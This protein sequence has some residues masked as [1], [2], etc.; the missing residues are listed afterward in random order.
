MCNT[1]NSN[2]MQNILFNPMQKFMHSESDSL[3]VV[4]VRYDICQQMVCSEVDALLLLDCQN[5]FSQKWEQSTIAHT[6]VLNDL[7]TGQ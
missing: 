2:W 7:K 3:S 4:V 5:Q 6:L 1:P